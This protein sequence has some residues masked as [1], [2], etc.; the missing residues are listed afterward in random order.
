MQPKNGADLLFTAGR[1]LFDRR[2]ANAAP[3][4][5]GAGGRAPMTAGFDPGCRRCPRLAAFLQTVRERHPT[6]HARPVPPFG[7]PDPRLLIVGL[8]PGMHGANATGRPFTSVADPSGKS[9]T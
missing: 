1:R 4:I 6:Y 7:D 2:R 8:A 9:S 5:R 3:A